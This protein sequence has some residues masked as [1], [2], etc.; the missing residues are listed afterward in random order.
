MED[1]SQKG[2][3]ER[4]ILMSVLFWMVFV[5]FSSL[6]YWSV[7]MTFFSSCGVVI[8]SVV[9]TWFI[10][11]KYPVE[12]MPL[13]SPKKLDR[14]FVFC[15]ISF[16]CD[17]GIGIFLW[18]QRNDFPL[19]TPWFATSV[20][21]FLLF[22][23]STFFLL[24]ASRRP[25][26]FFLIQ[27]V[28]HFFILYGV[29]LIVFRYGFGYDPIIHQATEKYI[30]A[31]GKIFPLQPFYIGQYASVVALH[32]LTALPIEFID[33]M[34]VP[35]LASAFIPLVAYSGLRRAWGCSEPRAA[36]GVCL[37][38]FFPFSE[39]TFTV[40]H[41]LTVLYSVLFIFLFPLFKKNI[42]F[43]LL[44]LI[45]SLTALVT[46]PLLGVPLCLMLMCVFF[47]SKK[48]HHSLVASICIGLG[49]GLVLPFLFGVYSSIHGSSFFQSIS[50]HYFF[51]SLILLFRSPYSL[52]D[53]PFLWAFL[54]RMVDGIKIFLYGISLYALWRYKN[55]WIRSCVFAILCTLSVSCILLITLI[56]IPGIREI[57]QA[58]YALR[59]RDVLPFL[60]LPFFVS[61]AHQLVS[62][63]KKRN[64]EIFIFTL[65]SLCVCVQW[66]FAYPQVN[67]VTHSAGWNVS[68]SDSVVVRNIEAH[69]LGN[70]YAVLSDRLSAVVAL[71]ELGFEK[72]LH[73]PN[74]EMVYPY[75]I[76][77]THVLTAQWY[78]LLIG[79]F[80]QY[81]IQVIKYNLGVQK[82]YVV[83]HDYQVGRT[84]IERS[85]QS[86]GA[87][88]I[89]RLPFISIYTF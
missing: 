12:S 85:L 86:V 84:G 38:L 66:Y 34:L 37:L 42:F 33:R 1:R 71:R 69:A 3:G 54:Y 8:C 22:A 26:W 49:G 80:S 83:V 81:D 47:F 52:N 82:V 29:A 24:R 63:F 5:C 74:G 11:K 55:L 16:L 43:K 73:T 39:L 45:I 9:A 36:L 50:L 6:A 88:Q 19:Q 60:L 20:W 64:W 14:C 25:S 7:G 31:H 28:V 40:P 79:V 59:I 10:H 57:E 62:F 56:K 46:H 78:K 30:S 58:E 21:L 4:F 23:C 87:V 18:N 70:S 15:I 48:E 44:L 89:Q 32:F 13:F 75:P 27:A 72:M 65:C 76:S 41:N 77:E 67:P 61:A 2:I 35:V 53:V 51:Q 68:G 17:A